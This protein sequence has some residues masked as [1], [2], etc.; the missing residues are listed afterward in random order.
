MIPYSGK[1]NGDQ[2]PEGRGQRGGGVGLHTA[3]REKTMTN[4]EE[5]G[6]GNDSN[7][8]SIRL[9]I[10]SS[11]SPE[12]RSTK[13]GRKPGW[14]RFRPGRK[15]MGDGASL[16]ISF[17]F[18]QLFCGI[19]VWE[20]CHG[21]RRRRRRRRRRKTCQGT[22][23]SAQCCAMLPTGHGKEEK[24]PRKQKMKIREDR[25][26]NLQRQLGDFALVTNWLSEMEKI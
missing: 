15:K 21:R 14:F 9:L 7:S 10:S 8:C 11:G 4:H 1:E 17:H 20:I 5:N 24:M 25:A 23:L 13:A 12:A 26:E 3:K 16:F 18:L 22:W 19:L 6:K 2:T